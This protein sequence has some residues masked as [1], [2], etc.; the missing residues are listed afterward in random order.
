MTP[1][2]K[3]EVCGFIAL[4][5]TVGDGPCP[6]CGA[7]HEKVRPMPD[8]AAQKIYAAGRPNDIHM[9]LVTLAA[10][11]SDL[12]DE[13]VQIALDP[14]CVSGFKKSKDAAWMVKQLAKAEIASHVAKEK[15]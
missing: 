4:D 1:L 8:E 12:C 7:P 5:R 6:K 9:E 10:R 2:V 15:F 14:A 13:G 11:M 3:C